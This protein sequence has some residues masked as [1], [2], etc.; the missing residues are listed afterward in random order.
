MKSG[1]S[2][3]PPLARRVV[4]NGRTAKPSGR[5]LLRLKP[6]RICE[7]MGDYERYAMPQ[8]LPQRPADAAAWRALLRLGKR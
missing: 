8:T 5:A 7:S 1:G 3:G 6:S 4:R 2:P